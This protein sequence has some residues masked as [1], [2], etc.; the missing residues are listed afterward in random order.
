[1]I[2]RI[3]TSKLC[4]SIAL[5]LLFVFLFSFTILSQ[6]KSDELFFIAE[7]YVENENFE[8]AINLYHR[9]LEEKPNNAEIN[10]KLGFC[11]LN[12][13]DQKD[14]AIEYIEKSVNA[15]NK[16][17]KRQAS[18]YNIYKY[19]L[20]RAYQANYKFDEAVNHYIELKELSTNKQLHQI[21]EKELERCSEGR[22]LMDS[23][24]QMTITNLGINLNS[25]YSDHSPVVSADE[26]IM[27][28][29]SR[30][31]GPNSGEPDF[32]G[33]YDENIFI[34]YNNDGQWSE[35]ESIGPN[36][37]TSEHVA[38]IGVSVDG[39]TLL[40]Y[41]SDEEGSIF[42]STLVG[43]VWQPPVK[44][45]PTINTKSR[46]AD[47]CFSPDGNLLY[48]TSN[49]KGGYGGLDIYV[50][51]KLRNGEWSE[52]K[53]LGPNINTS[54]DERAP[55]MHADG[56]TLY[57]SSKG[58]GGLGGFDILSSRIN[59]FNTWSKPANI[60]YPINTTSDDVFYITSADRTR[61]YYA[62]NQERGY[63]RTDLYVIGLKEVDSPNLTVMTGKIFICRGNLPEVSIT[64]LDNKTDEVKGIYTPNSKTGKFLFVLN[65]GGEYKVI[66][67]SEGKIIN[68]EKLVIPENAAYQQLY[69]VV[70]IPVTPP[71]KDEEL[72]MLEEMEYIGG[73]NIDNI[74]ENGVIYD[75]SLKIEN[76]LFPFNQAQF[77]ENNSSL[78]KLAEY[79]A[80][81]PKAIIE[82][83]AYADAKGRAAYNYQLSLKRGESIKDYL[84][85]RKASPN[86]LVV[87]GYGEENPIALNK[88]ADGTWNIEGQNFNRRIEFRVLQ[89]GTTTLLVKPIT[90]LPQEIKNKNY[91]YNY[92]KSPTV[93]LESEL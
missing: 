29:T 91:K 62:S 52:A 71:C 64:V 57:F 11:Y 61:A 81:N 31:K 79:L 25:E 7:N 15:T 74:D 44:L 45:G 67:E 50:S 33:E 48:F 35:P 39:Q 38:S 68:Q 17:R 42:T 54:E 2:N 58:H 90:D 9:I 92:K 21:I 5:T 43:D 18:T 30:R 76:I 22:K 51:Y 12:S 40:I 23:P 53:N 46:E 93:H 66:F 37:N 84:V 59:E 10:F 19:Y 1:M 72:A 60:G 77:I 85:K 73:I 47:A 49:R 83:G 4:N 69:K 24:V 65:K 8:G 3:N 88:N 75:E 26:S 41:K 36:I 56:V 32:G 70:Q 20:A 55:F 89:Q 82:I 86:Q 28:F 34:S 14:K 6:E 63:G 13:V 27:I 16:K 87:V 80:S 78:N